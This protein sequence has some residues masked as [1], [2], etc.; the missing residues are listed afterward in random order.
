MSARVD[1]YTTLQPVRVS[2]LSWNVGARKPPPD[3]ELA[4]LVSTQLEAGCDL[5]VIGLQVTYFL[6]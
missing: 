6:T 5:L 1:D 3:A 2:V 4:S